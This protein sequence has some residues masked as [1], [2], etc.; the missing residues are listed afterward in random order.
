[1]SNKEIDSFDTHDLTEL[2]PVVDLGKGSGM[3]DEEIDAFVNLF[4]YT[5][6]HYAMYM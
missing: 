4:R 5:Y 6:V 1:M 2:L 3:T